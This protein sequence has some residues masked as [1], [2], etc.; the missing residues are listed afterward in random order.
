[1]KTQKFILLIIVAMLP[2]AVFAHAPKKV[3]LSY[4]SESG[5][6]SISVTHP[7]KDVEDHLIDPIVIM[8][9][10][11]EVKKLNYKSQSSLENHE[12]EVELPDLKPG[13]IVKVKAVCNKLGSKTG[14]LEI[15]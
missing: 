1:M 9:N 14:K 13:D 3:N 5:I 12:I 8:V 10:D 15:K 2:M 6:L 7:V 4:D 11:V